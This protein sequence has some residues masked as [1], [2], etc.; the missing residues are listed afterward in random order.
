M[1][2]FGTTTSNYINF[3]NIAALFETCFG[4]LNASAELEQQV[5]FLQDCIPWHIHYH[6]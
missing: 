1:A 2:A 6:K 5:A 4:Q 3:V